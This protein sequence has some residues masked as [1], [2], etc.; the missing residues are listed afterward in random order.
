MIVLRSWVMAE[1]VTAMTGIRRGRIV[2]DLA[3][4]CDPVDAGQLN[5]H[6]DEVRVKLTGEPD[7][8]FARFRF[9]EPI[10]L[11]REHVAH[12]LP[13]LVVVL[14]NEDQLIGHGAPEV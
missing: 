5:V 12:Q 4:C 7:A 11:E 6:Q 8:I 10:A 13:V 2:P 9:G 3:E 1:A 14:D